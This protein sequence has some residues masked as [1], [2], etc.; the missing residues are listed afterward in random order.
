MADAE[1]DAGKWPA[2]WP[3]KFA[4]A[5]KWDENIVLREQMRRTGKLLLWDTP[6]S[7]GVANKTSLRLNRFAIAAVLEVWVETSD[8]P[9][10]PPIGWLRA[11]VRKVHQMLCSRQD[12]VN[13]YVDDWGSK[14]L[15]SWAIRRFRTG[16]VVFR[17]PML[18]PLMVIMSARWDIPTEGDGDDDDADG[19]DFSEGHAAAEDDGITPAGAEALH[20]DRATLDEDPYGFFARVSDDATVHYSAFEELPGPEGTALPDDKLGRSCEVVPIATPLRNLSSMVWDCQAE[21][22]PDE[23]FNG[24]AGCFALISSMSDCGT[25]SEASASVVASAA[26]ASVV[27]AS[28]LPDAAN[29]DLASS[30]ASHPMIPATAVIP[31]NVSASCAAIQ[32]A[33]SAALCPVIPN[34]M[35]AASGPAVHDATSAASCPVSD[36]VSSLPNHDI[37]SAAS[38]AVMPASDVCAAAVPNNSAPVEDASSTA[39]L[40]SVIP[41]D[42]SAKAPPMD[43]ASSAASLPA[44]IPSDVS[45]SAPPKDNGNSAAS[46]PAVIPSDVSASAPPV[47]NGSSAASLPAVIPSDVSASAPPVDNASSAA[48]FSA[49]IPGDVS[50]SAPPMDDASS[51]ASLPAEIHSDVSASAPALDNGSSAASLPTAI[52]LGSD[53]S[54]SAAPIDYASSVSC[55]PRSDN[56]SSEASPAVPAASAPASLPAY[57][58]TVVCQ[59]VAPHVNEDPSKLQGPTDT[60]ASFAKPPKRSGSTVNGD[61]WPK[62]ERLKAL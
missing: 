20:L 62:I 17:D 49:V 39:S 50:A 43:N 31:S 27:S 7:T 11:E 12:I 44:V 8:S 61:L 51:A 45:A 42:V 55:A 19:A 26:A 33:S 24:G 6:A 28:A 40:P 29:H 58:D 57:Q 25:A 34:D 18:Q 22:V 23:L 30:A 5:R 9:K 41:R 48:S 59:P 37:S 14:R 1:S 3:P 46:L 2:S 35:S 32:D 38:C 54:A 53:V 10:S 52:P 60:S 36:V 21:T 16:Q 15:A 13:Q 47:D 56:A 4:L